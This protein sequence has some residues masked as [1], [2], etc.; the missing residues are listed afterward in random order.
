MSNVEGRGP[1]DRSPLIPPPPTPIMPLCNFFRLMHSTFSRVNL[2]T[3]TKENRGRGRRRDRGRDRGRDMGRGRGRTGARAG[4]G[5]GAGGGT[6]T[7]G[8]RGGGRGS[9]GEGAEAEAGAGEEKGQVEGQGDPP[10]SP[11]RLC[12]TIFSFD[13]SRV[14]LNGKTRG[15]D[16]DVH[17]YIVLPK[18]SFCTPSPAS[19]PLQLQEQQQHLYLNSVR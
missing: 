10:P 12:V 18:R 14:K 3:H 17:S 11:S 5:A 2:D 7:G 19:P 8:G 4:G 16:T 13:A 15:L 1:I 9:G 6:G